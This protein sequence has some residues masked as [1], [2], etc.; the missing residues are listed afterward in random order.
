MAVYII[1]TALTVAM[2]CPVQKPVCGGNNTENDGKRM[3][4][5]R[6]RFRRGQLCNIVCLTGIFTLLFAVS[7]CR[8]RVGNDYTRY[9]E[10]FHLIPLKQVVPTEFGF[11]RIVLLMQ[12]L[13]GID[14]KLTIF[15]LFAFV[16]VFFMV[17]A[18][19]DQ[20]ENFLFSF[21]LFMTLSY[22]FQSLNTVRYYLAWAVAVFSMKYVLKKQYGRFI[23]LILLTATIHKSVLLVIPVYILA[24]FPWKRWQ[25]FVLAAVSASGIFLKDL[26]LKAVVLLYP[27]Y[28]NT[29]YLDGGTSVINIVRIIGVLVFT[30]IYYRQ[31]IAEDRQNRFY[32]QL[33]IFALLLYLCGSFIP[34]I[35]R[36]GYYMTAGHIFLLPSV[37]A[38][39]ED[40][41]Q[42]RFW[43]AVIV[44]A[45]VLYFG[46]F[47]IKAQDLLV[48]IVPYHT[49]IFERPV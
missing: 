39:I 2:A 29:S 14:T 7:A 19:Y 41:R 22:Y 20:S 35:S 1:L 38:K 37:I 25:I 10:F 32:F 11:N 42:R 43:T 18:V 6:P 4:I 47:L 26:Y 23:L 49:W 31:A 30:L 21:F 15:A 17:K 36:V 45:A 33:N 34:E 16:T 8:Y 12:F 48:R 40:R 3:G 28:E 9:E 24:N 44:L 13:F 27:S 46:I 5:V